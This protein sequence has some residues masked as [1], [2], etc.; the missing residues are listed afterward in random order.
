MSDAV[1]MIDPEL[2]A[3]LGIE[4]DTPLTH[5]SDNQG[6]AEGAVMVEKA[7]VDLNERSFPEIK[8]RFADTPHAVFSNP[9]AYYKEATANEGEGSA[10]LQT[11]LQKYVNAKD[12]RDKSVYRQQLI[13]AYWDFLKSVAK[14]A[15]GNLPDA[16]KYLLRFGMLHPSFLDEQGR[17]FFAKII[18]ENEYNQPI[19]YLDEWFEAVGSGAVKASSTDEAGAAKGGTNNLQKQLFD[20]AIGKLEGIKSLLKAKAAERI[21]QEE[22]LTAAVQTA[23]AHTPTAKT[24]EVSECYSPT[25]KTSFTEIQDVVKKLL[26]IDREIASLTRDMNNTETDAEALRAKAEAAIAE[27]SVDA[28]A[29]DGEFDTVRQ[30]SKMTVG[31]QGNHYPILTKEYLHCGPHDVASR[32]NVIAALAWVESIDEKAFYRYHRN[33][34][35]RIVP[36]VILLPNYGDFGFCWEPFDRFNRASSRGRIAVPMYSKN[37]REALLAGIGDLRW[38]IAKEKAAYYWMEEGLTGRYYQWFNAKKLKGDVK[39]AFIQDY[40]TWVTK[41]SE[42]TQKLDK[43]VRN[44]FWYHIPFAQPIKDKLKGRSFIY[45]ELYQ[46][47]LNRAMSDGY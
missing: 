35:N 36:F 22:L 11:L 13:P 33:K 28:R 27:S 3:L 24:P 8:K 7:E 18:V 14:K 46:K 45:Q 34:L 41:E 43:E 25:Q 47:D 4:A 2:A 9:P 20:K 12:V 5:S 42:G 17:T 23:T 21:S 37:L 39:E 38:H 26:S 30:M 10:R 19:Y 15:P 40:I 6:E 16:K 44:M 1:N 31:R 32:E 29:V